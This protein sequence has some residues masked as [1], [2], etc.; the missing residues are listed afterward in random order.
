ML[1]IHC[2]DAHMQGFLADTN[3]RVE[4]RLAKAV[5]DRTGKPTKDA[6]LP[7]AFIAASL[8]HRSTSRK[9]ANLRF[10]DAREPASPD[11][12]ARARASDSKALQEEEEE[13]SRGTNGHPTR[14]SSRD[15]MDTAM[16]QLDRWL[17]ASTPSRPGF[18]PRFDLI[19]SS[20]DLR[21]G[22]SRQDPHPGPIK[23]CFGAEPLR[24]KH[25]R[26]SLS[27]WHVKVPRPVGLRS[28]NF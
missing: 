11:S 12:A 22:L 14:P 13:R 25:L 2:R 7:A 17:P 21:T 8:R 24:F 9:Q 6:S 10:Q 15:F 18:I 27:S 23:L 1:G 16:P 19:S 28:Q 26:I 5:D 20:R 3:I 4:I